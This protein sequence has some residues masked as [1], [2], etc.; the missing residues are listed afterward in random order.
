MYRGEPVKKVV[1]FYFSVTGNTWWVTG[2]LIGHL[3]DIGLDAFS[4]SIEQVDIAQANR[5]IA[6]CHTVGVQLRNDIGVDTGV[7]T[8]CGYCVKLC[9]VGNL[10]LDGN[11]FET[12]GTCII[13]LRCY[14]FCPVSAVTYMK[15]RHDLKRGVPYRGPVEGFDPEVMRPIIKLEQ[16]GLQIPPGN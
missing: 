3:K 2:R 14:S 4:Y 16:T 8:Y 9:P 15:K 13:C 5:W 10:A 1:V 11:R 7:C 6:E 12:R